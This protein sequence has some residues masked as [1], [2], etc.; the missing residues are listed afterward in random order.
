M[1]GNLALAD[2]F[3]GST[4]RGDEFGQWCVRSVGA[5]R[6]VQPLTARAKS[7]VFAGWQKLAVMTGI[8]T[9]AEVYVPFDQ[10]PG[11]FQR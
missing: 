9:V 8:D 11:I 6:A 1:A 7:T 2:V 5:T 3:D 4:Q 10:P